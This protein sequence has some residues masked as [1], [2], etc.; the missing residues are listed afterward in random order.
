MT[1]FNGPAVHPKM[2][3]ITFECSNVILASPL[4]ICQAIADVD[5]WLEFSGYAFLPGIASAVY[6]THTVG[7]VGSRIRVRNTDGSE[8]M[9]EVIEWQDG[10]KVVMKLHNFTP[11]L[12]LLA[13]H[14]LETWRFAAQNGSTLVTRQLQMI[15]RH[16]WTRPLLWLI[17][18]L[19]RQAIA[20]HL[21]EMAG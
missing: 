9:E 7:M 5:R 2:Q 3:P 14:F 10:E 18:L 20:Q 19:F 21:K 11:P 15:P 16:F 12:S 17:S 6:V 8:H 1:S 13:T 4:E